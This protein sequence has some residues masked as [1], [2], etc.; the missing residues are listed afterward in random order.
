MS[1]TKD[2]LAHELDKMLETA[3]ENGKDSLTVSVQ[4]LHNAGEADGN[5]PGD[6]MAEAERVLRAAMGAG[7]SE[8]PGDGFAVAFKLP[9]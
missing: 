1:D 4:D 3:E 9:R 6:T 7:D 8:A 2:H 5:L